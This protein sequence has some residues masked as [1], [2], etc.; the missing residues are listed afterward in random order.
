MSAPYQPVITSRM[1]GNSAPAVVEHPG[2]WPTSR[3]DDDMPK[4]NLTPVAA[5][6]WPKV[7]QSG[8][9]DAC[10]PWT[11][12]TNGPLGYGMIQLGRREDGRIKS[13]RW[14][15]L[16]AHGYLP[17][18]VMHECDNP[19]CCNPLHLSPGDHLENAKGKVARGRHH[20]QGKTHCPSG[21]A[22]DAANTHM[23]RGRRYCRACDRA[24]S[25]KRVR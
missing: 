12:A 4:H 20:E 16:Q 7:D 18:V 17:T 6:F 24:R 21:H 3:E 14:V 8:G 5:R 11:G 22:Y 19:P 13:H 1:Q 23:Y 10:W 9:L 2:A 15:F 25:R